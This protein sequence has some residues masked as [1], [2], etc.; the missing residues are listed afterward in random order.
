MNPVKVT[1]KRKPQVKYLSLNFCASLIWDRNKHMK[2]F[3]IVVYH[4]IKIWIKSSDLKKKKKKSTIFSQISGHKYL[5]IN[6][7]L[8]IPI[9]ERN[10]SQ[11]LWSWKPE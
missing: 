9:P 1:I 5:R 10:K 3:T 6:S 11:T 8:D 4:G 7:I 2:N